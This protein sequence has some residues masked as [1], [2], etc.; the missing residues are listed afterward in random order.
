MSP[1]QE[2][3]IRKNI[4]DYIKFAK[5]DGVIGMSVANLKQVTTTKGVT[6]PVGEYH[7]EFERLAA[8][9]AKKLKF[10]VGHDGQK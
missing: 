6:I 1:D 10:Q 8:E 7:R 3:Q 4:G 2:T 5:K 9:V